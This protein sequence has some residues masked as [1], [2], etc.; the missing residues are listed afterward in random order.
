M[1]GGP[2]TIYKQLEVKDLGSFTAYRNQAIKAVFQD[3]TIV[4]I[5]KD[6]RIIRVL[7]RKGDELLFNLD[8]PNPALKEYNDYIKVAQ[9]FFEFT[10]MTTDQKEEK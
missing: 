6:C 1:A 5:M 4:R 7:N 10:F 2:D 8:H 9:E 3:R